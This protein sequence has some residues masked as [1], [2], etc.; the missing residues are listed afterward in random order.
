MNPLKV[1]Q[2]PSISSSETN[3]QVN[4]DSQKLLGSN[5][6]EITNNTSNLNEQETKQPTNIL[7][8]PNG[9]NMINVNNTKQQKLLK[10][11][12]ICNYSNQQTPISNRNT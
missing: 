8:Q 2:H 10:R 3:K 12:F 6:L 9:T 5:Q 1:K 11:S 4:D 7:T